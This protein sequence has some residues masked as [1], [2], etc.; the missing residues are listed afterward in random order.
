MPYKLIKIE[1]E[2]TNDG[3]QFVA[4]VHQEGAEQ[5]FRVV[6]EHF[7]ST[8]E[9]TEQVERWIAVREEEDALRIKNEKQDKQDSI[10]E[11]INKTL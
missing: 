7:E 11:E 10:V 2:N 5:P 4:L 6:L 9:A 1:K 8:E 3:T